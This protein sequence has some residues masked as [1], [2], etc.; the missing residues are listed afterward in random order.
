LDRLSMI[1]DTVRKLC[2]EQ[3][4]QGGKITGVSTNEIAEQLKMQRTN[5]SSD[6]NALVHQGKL[7][8]IKGKPV[9]YKTGAAGAGQETM[10]ETCVFDRVAGADGSLKTAIQQAKAAIMYPPSGLHTLLLGET[11][12]GKSMFAELMYTYA[13]EIGRVRKN[14]PFI[15]FNCADYS[16]NPQLLLAQLFGIKKGSYTGADEDR[17]GL[18]ENAN[19]GVLFL[20]EVH[21]L[22]P[23][24]QEMLF[25]LIDRGLYN[26]LGEAGTGRKAQVIIICATTEN[27]DSVL[28]RTFIRR[29]PMIIKIP[30]LG[31]RTPGERWHLIK[32]FFKQE[33][34]CL[35]TPIKVSGNSLKAFLL[36]DC[37]NNIGQLKSDI[38]LSCAKAFLEYMSDKDKGLQIRSRSLP[39]NVRQ[40]LL[41]LK[42]SGNILN[43]LNI[44]DEDIVFSATQ[45]KISFPEPEGSFNIYEIMEKKINALKAKGLE[46]KE[47]RLIVSLDVEND[48]KKYMSKFNTENL[49]QLYNIVD[50]K[51]VDVT[52]QFLNYALKQLG[53]QYE[54]KILYGLSIHVSSTLERIKNG[55]PIFHPHLDDIKKSYPV[56][57]EVA[58]KIRPML[59]DNF[60]VD[61]PEDE[62]GFITTF[63]VMDDYSRNKGSGRVGVIVAM[64]GGSTATSMVE[65]VNRLLGQN[66]A[67][68]YNMPLDQKPETAL[69]NLTQIVK[70]IDE[71]QG[72]LMMVDMGSLV[73]F[74]DIIYEKTGI[75]IKTIEMVST[76]LVLEAT[77]KAVMLSS[78]EEIYY[79]VIN[80]SPYL[81]RIYTDNNNYENKLDDR[82]II[83]ACITG[84]GTAIKL[85]NIVEKSLKQEGKRVDVIPI[86]ITGINDYHKKLSKI[87]QQKNIIAV[88][89]SI[90]P[91]DESL[92]YISPKEL[93]SGNGLK[94]I[95]QKVQRDENMELI[96]EMR[97]SIENNVDIDAGKFIAGFTEFYL[98]LKSSG[99]ELDGDML[100]GLGLHLACIIERI[101]N[102]KKLIKLEDTQGILKLYREDHEI[103]KKAMEQLEASFGIKLPADEFATIIKLLH[104]ADDIHIDTHAAG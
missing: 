56:E 99:L 17:A 38:K 28:L 7:E 58:S 68:A 8:K 45:E 54:E 57:F 29:I 102:G 37:P 94:I 91:K 4:Q 53:K 85:K 64:H 16:N 26:R 34:G 1:Y 65:V 78:L 86:G 2:E 63:L 40:G 11:G 12:V 33:A 35:K 21:R 42:E 30:C 96:Y 66:H 10:P 22:P 13:Q 87:K 67:A 93:I 70:E 3:M 72:I 9:L 84:E 90:K 82:V 20:D 51:L 24:G 59:K 88:I 5:A 83:T 69:D 79:S 74:G 95:D 18:V 15:S 49:Q 71:G 47:I 104:L 60:Q 98:K 14:S 27:A 80:I 55:K 81:G 43:E 39:E 97:P 44:T 23:E 41:K 36:Y 46:D 100:A 48:I 89:S 25:N 73:F 75:P 76:P 19:G 31:E 77:R 103:M 32:S 62:I 101:L 50:K 92:T 52:K 61:I 6:L